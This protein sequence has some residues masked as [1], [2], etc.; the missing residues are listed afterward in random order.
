MHHSHRPH[1]RIKSLALGSALTAALTAGTW[2]SHAQDAAAPAVN[3]QDA[4]AMKL[5]R[6]VETRALDVVKRGADDVMFTM[7]SD[8]PGLA[9]TFA[10]RLPSGM[11]LMAVHQPKSVVATDS[12]GTDLSNVEPGFNDEIEFVDVEHDFKDDDDVTEITLQLAPAARKASTF[13]AATAFE[14]TVFT[15][16]KPLSIDAGAE[17]TALPVEMTQGDAKARIR[18]TDDGIAIEPASLEAAIEKIELQTGPNEQVDSNGWF[19]D[20]TTITYMFDELPKQKP[21]KLMLTVRTG[22]RKVPLTIDVKDQPL[23]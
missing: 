3:G 7:S 5:T 1:H 19:A 11:K 14:A 21:V 16:V 18:A 12:E 15:G 6:I 8:Q 22:V 23:P 13:N 10:V 9:L 2:R 20:G 4:P 17:W